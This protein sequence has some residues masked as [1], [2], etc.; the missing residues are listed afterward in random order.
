MR[1]SRKKIEVKVKLKRLVD[2]PM[3]QLP[4]ELFVAKDALQFPTLSY[5]PYSDLKS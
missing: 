5:L 4:V 1:Y 3:T 2:L